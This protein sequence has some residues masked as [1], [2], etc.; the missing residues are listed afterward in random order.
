[1]I[2]SNVIITGVPRSGTTLT[3]YLLNQLPDTVALHEPM[4][5]SVFSKLK[6]D[7]SICDEIDRYLE[8]T[9]VSIETQK[10]AISRHVNGLVPDNHFG[11]QRSDSGLRKSMASFGEISITKELSTN[12]LL[13]IK[14][15]AEFT[16]IL[17]S[18]S[19]RF[20]CYAVIRNP[21]SV[22][23]S[24][25]SCEVPVANGHAPNAENLDI[26]LAQAL[27]Q[28]DDKTERQLHLLDW[29]YGKYWKVLPNSRILRYEDIISSGGKALAVISPPARELNEMLESKN[30]NI[31]YDMKLMQLLG[32]RILKTDGAFWEFYSKD[33]VE[34]L[35]RDS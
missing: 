11:D 18:L 29:Y 31:L 26:N 35:L 7:D 16:A 12:F 30:K 27:S 33:S 6:S 22:L 15:P 24:W 9:R 34:L 19:K 5:M 1:M 4:D 8:A 20:P 32:E 21:L 28:I 10:V 2:K 17:E 23:T 3:C 13:A 25:N 14:H